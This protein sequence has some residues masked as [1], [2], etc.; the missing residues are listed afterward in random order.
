M[1]ILISTECGFPISPAIIVVTAQDILKSIFCQIHS[2]IF[3]K[4]FFLSH[5]YNCHGKKLMQETTKC[6]SFREYSTRKLK[7]CN[8]TTAFRLNNSFKLLTYIP[9]KYLKEK[10]KKMKRKDV[11]KFF[12]DFGLLVTEII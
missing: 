1:K 3:V 4:K 11:R 2:T 12:F 8:C 10:L 6:W 5:S 9:I 7:I